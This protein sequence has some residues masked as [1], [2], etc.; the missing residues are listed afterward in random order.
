MDVF[1][2]AKTNSGKVWSGVQMCLKVMGTIDG[3][4]S[5]AA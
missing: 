3:S 2:F 1:P 5:V 4:T